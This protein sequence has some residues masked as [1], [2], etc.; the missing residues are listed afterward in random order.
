[1]RF[2]HLITISRPRF[3]LYE[4]GTFFIGVFAGIHTFDPAVVVPVLVFGAYF[5]FPANVLIYGINDVFD[6]ETDL[7]NP[8]KQGY[9]QVLDKSVHRKTLWIIFWTSIPFVLY[10]IT[11]PAPAVSAF[12]AFILFA[13]FYSA[14]PVRAKTKPFIDSFFSA[15]HYVATG[16][17]GYLLV[18]G[19][20]DW[21]P[22]AIAGM[23][24]AAA[25]HAYSAIPDIAADKAVGMKTVAILL[26]AKKTIVICAGLYA[27][28]AIISALY[29]GW[30]AFI[31]LIPYWFLLG[32]SYST[33]DDSLMKIYK[34]FPLL[35]ASVGMVLTLLVLV[36]SP[37]L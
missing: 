15:G 1:M 29:I 14:P 24:W 27:V 19:T 6:Y 26:G 33:P 36:Q 21:V 32:L 22:L 23:C 5:L 17:F 16:V 20:A 25:M 28:A 30:I 8:K 10:A 2:A 11:L 7:Q 3:W 4:F 13:V 18:S 34:K 37:L 35:N 12:V 9:E 31:L